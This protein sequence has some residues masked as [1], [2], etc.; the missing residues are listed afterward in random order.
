MAVSTIKSLKTTGNATRVAGASGQITWDRHDNMVT[1]IG[2]V[3]LTSSLNSGSN[4]FTNLPIPAV[5]DIAPVL[6]INSSTGVSEMAYIQNGT[7]K[8]SGT[9]ASGYHRICGSYLAN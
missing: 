9:W 3:Q 1:F 2:F 8:T 7:L 4:L 6:V 5:S